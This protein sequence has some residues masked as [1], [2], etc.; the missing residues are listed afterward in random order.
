MRPFTP[1]TRSSCPPTNSVTIIQ[2]QVPHFNIIYVHYSANNW[3]VTVDKQQDISDYSNSSYNSVTEAVS[4]GHDDNSRSFQ[5]QSFL[6]D[7]GTV[8][9]RHWRQSCPEQSCPVRRWLPPALVVPPH[10]AVT[11]VVDLRTGS[12]T[13]SHKRWSQVPALCDLCTWNKQIT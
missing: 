5:I 13:L 10:C 6:C 4:S 2:H 8:V 9:P 7:S 3:S 12:Q 1:A 11:S